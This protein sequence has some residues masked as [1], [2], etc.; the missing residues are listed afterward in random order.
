M[1]GDTCAMPVVEAVVLGVVQG[2][3][4]F[5][6]ISSTA[7][8]RVVPALLGW[9]DPGVAY[10]A[11]IQLGS[12]L[13]V[14]AYFCKDLWAI[15]SGSVTAIKSKD[16][17]NHD[18]RLLFAIM[19][20]TVPICLVGL[21]LK[22]MI[23]DPEGPFRSLIVIGCASIFMGI[24][25]FIAE[26]MAKKRRTIADLGVRDGLIVGL[27][28]CLALIPGCSRSGSTLTTALFMDMKREDAARFSFLLGI[29]AIVLSG[30]MELKDMLETGLGESGMMSLGVGLLVSAIVSYAAIWWLLK[31]LQNHS[32]VAF[33]IYRLI[34]GVSV[35]VL[36]LN[37]QIH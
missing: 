11:V 5:L 22:K 26:K 30:L 16:L 33:V 25:L 9:P 32:T 36:T 29:P 2:L 17:E 6:P 4:E 31:Y 18:L 28:Q 35:I 13:A 20:G 3:S 27:G 23:E 14:L 21:A 7:H 24:V 15:F 12:V 10:S 8:L 34:F 37:H 1:T 19:L